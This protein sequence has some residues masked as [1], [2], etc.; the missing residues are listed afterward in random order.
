MTVGQRMTR[1]PI[2]ARPE[3]TVPDAQALMRK[4][5]VSRLPVL[6]K[7]NKLVGI[8]TYS[9]LIHA[10]PSSATTLDMYEMHYLISKLKIEKVMT[11]KVITI[12]ENTTIEE[13][14]KIMDDNQIGALPIMRGELLVG[15]ITESDLF[16]LFIEL[17]GA[18]KKG[19]RITILV[20]EKTGELAA[21]TQ[22]IAAKGGNIISL[23]TFLG[24]DVSNGMC[25]MKVEGIGRDDIV[26][27]L[28]PLIERL[29]DLREV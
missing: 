28:Q 25:T 13:A 27:A 18:R 12:D 11:R 24:E 2:M 1:N 6:D 23:V 21:L 3:T 4:E 7:D 9:D 20:P 5:K 10:Q 17:F 29:V 15:I 14:A 26:A 19:M 8:V 22:A 16:R